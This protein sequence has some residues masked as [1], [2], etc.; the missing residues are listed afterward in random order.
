MS[1]PHVLQQI[2]GRLQSLPALDAGQL[3]LRVGGGGVR[4]GV[5]CGR[6][7][8]WRGG[9]G[10]DLCP[11]SCRAAGL[12]AVDPVLLLTFLGA[13]AD[14]LAP[15]A[16]LELSTPAVG[17]ETE[18]CSCYYCRACEHLETVQ[19]AVTV[20]T[21]GHLPDTGHP[22]LVST[23]SVH[24]HMQTGC[25][26]VRRSGRQLCLYTSVAFRVINGVCRIL[27]VSS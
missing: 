26:Q 8:G 19:L 22:V 25:R 1:A 24:A 7:G 13:V 11:E 20:G 16:L 10:G 2:V 15:A 23:P 21:P 4:L 14:N 9:G 12:V 6:L 17:T 27:Y 5:C 18:K 3:T